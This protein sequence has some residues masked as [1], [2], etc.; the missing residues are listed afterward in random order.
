MISGSI[1]EM[2]I[3]LNRLKIQRK[4]I[5]LFQKKLDKLSEKTFEKAYGYQKKVLHSEFVI[6]V[7]VESSDLEISQ[8]IQKKQEKYAADKVINI[9]KLAALPCDVLNHIKGFLTNETRFSLLEQKYKPMKLFLSMPRKQTF[10]LLRHIAGTCE[11]VLSTINDFY[12][13]GSPSWPLFD[14][15][16]SNMITN[17]SKNVTVFHEK[18]LLKY[19]LLKLLSLEKMKYMFDLSCAVVIQ[20]SKKYA[21][22]KNEQIKKMILNSVDL[23]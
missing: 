17:V 5:E 23:K 18:V 2:E 15:S 19:V 14:I 7:D 22:E 8:K 10:A 3:K 9:K 1:R 11:E 20:K 12:R 16:R 13:A 21:N 4:G 6:L